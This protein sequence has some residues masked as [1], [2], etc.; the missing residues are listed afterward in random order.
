MIR[1][2]FTVRLDICGRN[3][4]TPLAIV[5]CTIFLFGVGGSGRIP[6]EFTPRARLQQS[7]DPA[8]SGVRGGLAGPLGENGSR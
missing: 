3:L 2:G 7:A 6:V 8:G 5:D 1:H 4:R